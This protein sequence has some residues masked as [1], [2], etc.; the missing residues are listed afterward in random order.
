M[1]RKLDEYRQI[2]STDSLTHLPNCC[3][4]DE[5]LD[6]VF[7]GGF[8]RAQHFAARL[9]VLPYDKIA[10]SYTRQLC[11][12]LARDGDPIG[13]YDQLISG[14]ARSRGLIMVTNYRRE[15]DRVPGLRIEDWTV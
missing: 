5:W 9:K 8:G 11:A 10:A 7:E 3:A 12:E 4:F 2:A 14:H 13:P 6:L 1:R 15:F